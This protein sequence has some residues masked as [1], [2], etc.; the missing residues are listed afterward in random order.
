MLNRSLRS[1][2]FSLLMVCAAGMVMLIWQNRESINDAGVETAVQPIRLLVIGDSISNGHGLAVPWPTLLAKRLSLDV[3]N[4]SVSGEQTAW[5]LSQVDSTLAKHKPTHVMIMLGTNDVTKS[6][7]LESS[8]QN[9]QAMADRVN[10]S[11]A[12]AYLSTVLPIPGERYAKFNQRAAD[13]SDG[14]FSLAGI[15]VVDVRA[16]FVEPVAL[17]A[18]GLHPNQQGQELI[19]DTFIEVLSLSDQSTQPNPTRK[20]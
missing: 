16:R 5:G 15:E 9:L 8:L 6:A 11:G 18:D 1:I 10:S 19:A 14:I 3:I 17:L 12:L 13:L 4:H 7:S 20:G 2:A